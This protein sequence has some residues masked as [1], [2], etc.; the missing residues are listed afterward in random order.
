MLES[1]KMHVLLNQKHFTAVYPHSCAGECHSLNDWLS[2]WERQA[3]KV[4]QLV[5]HAVAFVSIFSTVCFQ[6]CPQRQAW[7]TI[8][9]TCSQEM[10]ETE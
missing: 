2:R 8:S 5:L 9:F 10:K 6:M 4:S 7:K 3:R 1:T